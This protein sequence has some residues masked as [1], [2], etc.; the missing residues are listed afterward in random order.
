MDYLNRCIMNYMQKWFNFS[1]IEEGKQNLK[2]AMELR[3]NMGGALYWNLCNDDCIEISRKLSDM[4]A[5]EYMKKY[6]ENLNN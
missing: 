3:D 5:E 4:E 2:E 1:T 6:Q